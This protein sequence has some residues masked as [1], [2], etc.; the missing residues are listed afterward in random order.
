M[1]DFWLQTEYRRYDYDWA[2]KVYLNGFV[3]YAFNGQGEKT[4]KEI[5]SRTGIDQPAG[6]HARTIAALRHRSVVFVGDSNLR[7]Q[8]LSLEKP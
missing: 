6:E 1:T 4:N 3:S 8:Y 7:Y 2:R 5:G